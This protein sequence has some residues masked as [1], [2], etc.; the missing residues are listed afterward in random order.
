MVVVDVMGALLRTKKR[1]VLTHFLV[2][3]KKIVSKFEPLWEHQNK[4]TNFDATVV[5]S[6]FCAGTAFTHFVQLFAITI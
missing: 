4:F 5:A 2:D 3:N 6:K 1:D